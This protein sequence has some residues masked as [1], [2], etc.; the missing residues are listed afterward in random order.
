MV[1][2]AESVAM[3]AQCGLPPGAAFNACLG[4]K[5]TAQ[6]R[7]RGRLEDSRVHPDKIYYRGLRQ[8]IG[9]VETQAEHPACS[10]TPRLNK[11]EWRL[12]Q[13]C[14]LLL[15][16]IVLTHHKVSIKTSVLLT[17]V[18][19]TRCCGSLPSSQSA[20][21]RG[22]VYTD[23]GLFSMAKGCKRCQTQIHPKHNNMT[24]IFSC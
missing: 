19:I 12:V 8:H 21:P 5:I 20:S 14:S 11:N 17:T 1:M 3:P 4:H 24:R 7:S 9:T 16:H 15:R 22:G 23:A 13:T 18:S 6:A 2:G 10:L